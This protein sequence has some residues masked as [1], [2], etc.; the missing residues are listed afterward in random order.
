[1]K[2]FV[3]RPETVVVADGVAAPHGLGPAEVKV[4][5]ET[6]QELD[7]EPE[8]EGRALGDGELILARS[9]QI[10]QAL[11]AVPSAFLDGDRARAFGHTVQIARQAGV[12]DEAVLLAIHGHRAGAELGKGRHT[13]V[14]VDVGRLGKRGPFHRDRGRSLLPWRVDVLG[15]GPRLSWPRL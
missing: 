6:A 10:L 11:A 8:A 2:S 14:L 5:L 7:L 9:E 15:L 3:A 13:A 12:V 1:M 4:A